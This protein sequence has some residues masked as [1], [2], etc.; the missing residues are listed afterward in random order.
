MGSSEDFNH[1]HLLNFI[2]LSELESLLRCVNLLSF[3]VLRG[4]F[5][6]LLKEW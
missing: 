6:M 5:G 4:R 1:N 2:T 3:E